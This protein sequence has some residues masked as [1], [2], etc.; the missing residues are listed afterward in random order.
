MMVLQWLYHHNKIY[1]KAAVM[2]EQ[3][4]TIWKSEDPPRQARARPRAPFPSR[5]H[6]F[7]DLAVVTQSDSWLKYADH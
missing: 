4:M 6:M 5:T 7:N 2:V 3:T 1:L